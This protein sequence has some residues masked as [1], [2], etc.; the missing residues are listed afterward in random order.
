MTQKII[1][2]MIIILFI[3]YVRSPKSH[4]HIFSAS[5]LLLKGNVSKSTNKEETTQ[6][7][8]ILIFTLLPA[9]SC[10]QLPFKQTI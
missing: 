10:V 4:L 7:Q 9:V 8:H 1:I 3:T 5:Q 2:I 6:L